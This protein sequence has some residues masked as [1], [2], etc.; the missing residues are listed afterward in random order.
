MR[1]N[2]LEDDDPFEPTHRGAAPESADDV[3]APHRRGARRAA[4]HAAMLAESAAGA[5]APKTP[6]AE[7]L[8]DT[9]TGA[10]PQP[11]RAAELDAIGAADRD[12]TA[13]PQ[14][15]LGVIFAG[16][17]AAL[18]VLIAGFVTGN[19][20]T[21]VAG[22]VMIVLCGISTAGI[23]RVTADTH[24]GEYILLVAGLA[25][26]LLASLLRYWIAF[27][28][29][30]YS[31]SDAKTYDDDGRRIA[32]EF[33][34][35]GHLPPYRSFTGSNFLRVLTGVLYSVIPPSTLAAFFVFGW[36][37]FWGYVMFWRAMRRIVVPPQDRRYLIL[38]MF[39]PSLAYWP[40]SLGKESVV[41]FALGLASLGYARSCTGSPLSGGVYTLAGV[42]LCAMVRPHVAIVVVI[43]IAAATVF[44]K[45]SQGTIVNAVLTGVLLLPAGAFALSQASAYFN[46]NV[47]S[48]A[49]VS[50]QLDAAGKRTAQGGSQC[51]DCEAVSPANPVQFPY[52][53]ITVILRPFPWES[54]SIQEFATS[55]EA[56]FVGFLLIKNFRKAINQIR[57]DN[58]YAIFAFVNLVVFIILFSNFNNFGILARQRTQIAPFL[59]LFLALPDRP[60]RKR[61]TSADRAW[62]EFEREPLA[63]R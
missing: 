22:I 27:S 35:H 16:A 54:P 63:T 48:S 42:A 61:R 39:M 38:L 50:S 23:K 13:P 29:T 3:P 8:D 57:R 52:A 12:P 2:W 5:R 37:S 26:K 15:A 53:A 62:D 24:H 11:S 6:S 18:G 44:Q 55:I 31:R 20:E 17:V 4:R 25:T 21:K 10:V 32:T 41:I 46:G 51:L 60:L 9:P 7:L 56:A 28:G 45:R 30:L 19:D 34:S 58:P 59:F 36:F 33:I 43:G 49:G 14:W 47:T 40:S 1:G